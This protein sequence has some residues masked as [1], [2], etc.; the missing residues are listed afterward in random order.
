VILDILLI[1]KA[2][3]NAREENVLKGILQ[4]LLQKLDK[5]SIINM[6][7]IKVIKLLYEQVILQEEDLLAMADQFEHLRPLIESIINND[8]I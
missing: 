8:L 4:V 1:E 7:A 6:T 3:M 2:V 5:Y